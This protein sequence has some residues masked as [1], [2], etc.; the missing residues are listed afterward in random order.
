MHSS[1][2]WVAAVATAAAACLLAVG[3]SAGAAGARSLGVSGPGRPAAPAP[4]GFKGGTDDLIVDGARY[5]IT[6]SADYDWT[7]DFDGGDGGQ[8]VDDATSIALSVTAGDDAGANCVFAG[9]VTGKHSIGSATAPGKY[10]CIAGKGS[11][12]VTAQSSPAVGGAVAPATFSKGTYTL[13]VN[14]VNGGTITF[15]GQNA[16]TSNFDGDDAG[17]WASGGSAFGFLVSSGAVGDVGC[18]FVGT[19]LAG[20]SGISSNARQSPYICPGGGIAGTWYAK[21]K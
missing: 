6:F 5:A 14:D 2:N 15:G 12:Y 8:W 10:G 18:L 20:R 13:V 11:W 7:S 4:A 16:F 3:V 19:V 17:T 21:K 1:K 9:T